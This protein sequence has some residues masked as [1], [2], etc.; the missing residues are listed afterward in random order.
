MI[1][2]NRGLFQSSRDEN[3]LNVDRQ[4]K[5]CFTDL[6]EVIVS[7]YGL[8]LTLFEYLIFYGYDTRHENIMKSVNITYSTSCCP[9]INYIGSSE[10]VFGN[11]T[12]KTMQ[13]MVLNF[14]ESTDNLTKTG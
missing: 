11:Q 14:T 5:Q 8:S 6:L 1:D 10:K 12:L 4:I 7:L 3:R 9:K 2:F 13:S